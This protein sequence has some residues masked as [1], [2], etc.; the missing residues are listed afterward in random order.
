MQKLFLTLLAVAAAVCGLT[1]SAQAI[2]FFQKIFADEYLEN[3]AD[4]EYVETLSKPPGKCLICHQGKK[5]KHHNNY[6]E[7]LEERLDKKTDKKD[8]DKVIAMLKEVAELPFDPE[9]P[10]GETFGDRIAAGKFPGADTM[11]ELKAEPDEEEDDDD[12]DDDDE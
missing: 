1:Q 7:H 10:D 4:A 5:K 11:D 3:H 2:P 9:D 8:T 12:D 6:G